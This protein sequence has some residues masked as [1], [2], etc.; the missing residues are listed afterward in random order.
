VGDAVFSYLILKKIKF[1]GLVSI[2]SSDWHIKRVK[3]IFSKI[4]E[5]NFKLEI[6]GTSE[7]KNM[8]SNTKNSINKKEE[9]SSRIFFEQ[10]SSYDKSLGSIEKFL[11]LNHKLY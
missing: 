7:I 1:N 8:D 5:K 11:E 6:L 3:S 9:E 4:Y 10:F 2:V